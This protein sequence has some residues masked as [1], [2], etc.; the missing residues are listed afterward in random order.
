MTD[1]DNTLERLSHQ[2]RPPLRVG[3][4]G[5]GMSGICMACKL[6]EAI[7]NVQLTL[8]ELND[9]LGGTWYT[10]R[11]PGVACDSP[12]HLYSFWFSPNSGMLLFLPFLGSKFDAIAE[13]ILLYHCW[14]R[15]LQ[16]QIRKWK[17]EPWLPTVSSS[18]T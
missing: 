15:R 8:F 13:T 9:Q 12:S 10:H 3:I 11:Y 5:G 4:I 18:Q 17:R 1:S 7:P 16:I 2:R 14:H 6:L